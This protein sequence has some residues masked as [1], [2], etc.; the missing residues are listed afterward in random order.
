MPILG[1]LLIIAAWLA[2]IATLWRTER[3]AEFGLVDVAL[4]AL[5]THQLSRVIAKEKIAYP[6]RRLFTEPD[7]ETP[8][9]GW[10]KAPGQLVTCPYCSSVWSA[11]FLVAVQIDALTIVLALAAVSSVLHAWRA[12]VS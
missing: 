4:L 1:Y 9:P 2:A 12:H 6:I 10:A 7:G 5:A 8:R 11:T 3:L